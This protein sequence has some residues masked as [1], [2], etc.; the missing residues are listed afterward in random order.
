MTNERAG[1]PNLCDALVMLDAFA[2]VG[3]HA[4]DLTLLDIEGRPV[5]APNSRYVHGKA[6]FMEKVS[7]ESLRQS[8]EQRLIAATAAQCS[9]IIRPRSPS[10]FLIQLDDFADE[11]LATGKAVRIVPHAFLT[12]CTSPGK[13]Q[14]W[15]AVADGPKELRDMEEAKLFRTRVRRGAQADH[16]ATGS[17]RIAGRVLP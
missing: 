8:I 4:F 9:F 13:H 16:S 1:Q 6:E 10:A 5:E 11:D 15:L 3:T 17:T 14:I 2:S 7:L 12:F